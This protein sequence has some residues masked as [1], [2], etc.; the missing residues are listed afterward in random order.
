MWKRDVGKKK[1][2]QN[3]PLSRTSSFFSL[4]RPPPTIVFILS[5]KPPDDWVPWVLWVLWPAACGFSAF[6]LPP[7]RF[8][9]KSMMIVV[10][11]VVC[12]SEMVVD[13]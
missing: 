5:M 2:S 11:G 1:K 13:E 3:A 8:L 10:G 6:L 12:V 7:A 4:A 9:I